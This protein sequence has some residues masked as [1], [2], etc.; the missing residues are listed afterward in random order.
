[1]SRLQRLQLAAEIGKLIAETWGVIKEK[2]R[3][4]RDAAKDA[5]IAKLQAKVEHLERKL[6]EAKK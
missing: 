6:A 3:E 2:R 1:M 4:D 5:A